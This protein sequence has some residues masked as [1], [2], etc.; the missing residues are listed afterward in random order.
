MRNG[1]PNVYGALAT[2]R[3]AE[4]QMQW[5]RAQLFISL[6]AVGLPV[7]A[8]IGTV[9]SF[10]A[11]LATVGCLINITWFLIAWRAES[12][13]Q[14]WHERMAQLEELDAG[15]E[16]DNSPQ[17]RIRVFAGEDIE[18][19]RRSGI[20]SFHLLLLLAFLAFL[21]WLYVLVAHTMRF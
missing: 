12:W 11:I 21:G 18:K 8:Q 13:T 1:E 6:N 16:D 4:A 2:M 19:V 5:S 15:Q 3:N 17:L 14:Y 7:V 20:R 10:S 9:T